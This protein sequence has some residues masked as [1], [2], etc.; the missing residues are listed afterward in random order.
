MLKLKKFIAALFMSLLVSC[1]T[2]SNVNA[3]EINISCASSNL[4]STSCMVVATATLDYESLTVVLKNNQK[5]YW[6]NGWGTN[7][8]Y[9][10]GT[11]VVLNKEF[12][13]DELADNEIMMYT[14]KNV[15]SCFRLFQPAG[16]TTGFK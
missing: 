2:I 10:K 6:C 8:C 16:C 12:S 14:T 7:E 9:L 4:S 15:L 11:F 13:L 3:G 5:F 1:G